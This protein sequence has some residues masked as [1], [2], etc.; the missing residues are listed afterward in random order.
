MAGV[1]ANIDIYFDK[2]QRPF[3]EATSL[4]DALFAQGWLHA[5]HR[6]WQM[7]L[8]RRAAQGQL[9]ALLGKSMVETD[10]ELYR[11]GIPQLVQRLKANSSALFEE[12]VQAYVR[13]VNAAIAELSSLP[14]EFVLLQAKVEAWSTQDVYAVGALM[15]FQSANNYESEILRLA[16]FNELPEALHDVFLNTDSANKT[17]PYI[18]KQGLSSEDLVATIGKRAHT[19]PN[20]K[21]LMPRF[22]FGSNGWVLSPKKSE[23][24]HALFAFDSH[25]ALGLPNLFYEVHLFF[26]DANDQKRQLRGWSVAG[27]PGVINGYNEHIAW[28]FTNIGDTQDV[29]TETRHPTEKNTFKDDDTWYKAVKTRYPIEVSGQKEPEYVDVIQTKNGFLISDSPALSLR[30]TIQDIRSRSIDAILAYNLAQD[31]EAFNKGVDMLAAPTLNATYADRRGNIGFRT[32]G[33]LP[34]RARG[35]GLYPLAGDN[36]KNRWRRI[37]DVQQMPRLYNPERGY[38]AAANARVNGADN[39]VLVSAENAADYR[40]QRLQNILSEDKRFTLDD[41][42]ALQLDWY[43][44]QAEKVLPVMLSVLKH[45]ADN[46]SV[47]AEI[48]DGL[49]LWLEAPFADKESAYA[50]IFQY[51]YRQ[52]AKDVFSSKLSSPLVSALLK[53]NYLV[54]HALDYLL[55]HAEAHPWW[56][57]KRSTFVAQSLNTSLKAI[58]KSLGSDR[59]QWQLQ[60]MHQVKLYHELG[61]AIPALDF[62]FN[63]KRVPWGGSTSTVGRASYRYDKDLNVSHGATVRVVAELASIPEVRANMPSGQSGHPFSKHYLDQFPQWIEGESKEIANTVSQ[64][65]KKTTL[66]LKVAP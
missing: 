28:G 58:E 12:Q 24:G 51:W 1:D 65:D 10:K 43:D 4:N 25:D 11:L 39:G 23:N 20:D 36:S 56:Q 45:Q 50:L 18:I 32:L 46:I 59:R 26:T 6:L 49:R 44:Q 47:D 66:H 42:E 63:S 15:A 62:F 61:K 7:E 60:S 38:I 54:N 48:M 53:E 64:L 14:P 13:G 52:L 34:E 35:D 3:V 37:V 8:F 19:N 5:S 16:L 40:I 33:L 27:L 22:A 17:Y 21:L 30:W 41:M 57:N 55:L 2:Y 31:W 29:F 9:S